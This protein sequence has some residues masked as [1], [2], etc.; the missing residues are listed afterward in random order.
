MKNLRSPAKSR[1]PR[2]LLVFGLV[3]LVTLLP[4]LYFILRS[5][6][7]TQA[8]WFHTD[9]QYR[10]KLPIANSGTA[11]TDFQFQFTLDTQTLITASKMQSNCNDIRFTDQTSG[12][13]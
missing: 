1:R 9:W 3:L 7:S 5:P 13:E 8:G 4:L 6:K 10:Q 12:K 11:Q 2:L